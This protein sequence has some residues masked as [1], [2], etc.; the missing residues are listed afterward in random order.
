[1]AD[2]TTF[3]FEECILYTGTVCTE[4][5][6]LLTTGFFS[7]GLTFGELDV[8]PFSELGDGF[9]FSVDGLDIAET[10]G[11]AVSDLRTGGATPFDALGALFTPWFLFSVDVS[12]VM[13]PTLTDRTLF[14]VLLA[15]FE[16]A[17]D[18]ASF[19]AILQA[20]YECPSCVPGGRGVTGF[21][22]GVLD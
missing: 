10:T 18:A 22:L 4:Q 1:M 17:A 8:P 5:S 16:F 19:M 13:L 15:V 20:K 7:G 6:T 12:L 11:L 21:W 2:L 14:A 9:L 3:C